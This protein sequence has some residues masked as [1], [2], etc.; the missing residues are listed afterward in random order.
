MKLT[1]TKKYIN[2]KTSDCRFQTNQISVKVH[3]DY[4]KYSLLRIL[5]VWQ[6]QENYKVSSPPFVFIHDCQNLNYFVSR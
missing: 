6:E 3:Y 1:L 4:E 5:I 2:F